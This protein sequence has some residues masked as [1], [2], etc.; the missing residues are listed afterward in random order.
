VTDQS[1]RDILPPG[2]PVLGFGTGTLLNNRRSRARALRLLE[3]A[4]DSGITWFDTAR[5]YGAG[6]V[7]QVLGELISRGRDQIIVA[8]KA[9]ILP[10]SRALP[11]RAMGLAARLLRRAAPPLRNWVTV[12]AAAQPRF[13][14]FE[15]NEFRTSVETSLRALKTDHIDILLLHECF[16]ADVEN[17]GLLEFLHRLKQ[18]GKIRAFGLGTGVD[19]TRDIL[20]AHPELSEVVQVPN[21]I[22]DMNIRLLPSGVGLPVTHSLLTSRFHALRERLVEN[23]SEARVWKAATGVDPRD[24]S[25]M[26][27]LMLTHAL[28]ANPRGVSL[29]FS[30]DTGHIAENARAVRER[31]FDT[32]QIDALERLIRLEMEGL[33]P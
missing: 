26:V 10:Q 15:L 25:S 28:R 20:A 24:V 19:Q 29:F 9:G 6:R 21:S 18:E 5:M 23:P 3:T 17:P 31:R 2:L 8:T 13:G 22:W 7:E 12:P 4:R 32:A 27:Q 11:M 33:S 1:L 16:P 14:A 30:T